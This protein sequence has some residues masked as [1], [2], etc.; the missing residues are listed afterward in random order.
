MISGLTAVMGSQVYRQ[1]LLFLHCSTDSFW[2]QKALLVQLCLL[3]LSDLGSLV[4]NLTQSLFPSCVKCGN[5]G[6]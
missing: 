6:S 2:S 3:G 1:V 5:N 4:P